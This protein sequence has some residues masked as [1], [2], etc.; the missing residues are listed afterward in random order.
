MLVVMRMDASFEFGKPY[1][2][3]TAE[4]DTGKEKRYPA[5]PWLLQGKR[6]AS[7]EPDKHVVLLIDAPGF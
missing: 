5:M 7:C 6:P 1:F 4:R 2:Q 3:G